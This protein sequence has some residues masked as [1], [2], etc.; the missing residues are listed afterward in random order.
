MN[1]RTERS[2]ILAATVVFASAIGLIALTPARPTRAL[3]IFSRRYST[4][5]QTCHTIPPKLNKTGIAFQ[6]NHFNWPGH[7]PPANYHE[8]IGAVPV[9]GLA[10]SLHAE[11]QNTHTLTAFQTLELFASDGFKV[12]PNKTGGYWL[13][14]FAATNNPGQSATDLD[15]AYVALPITGNHGQGDIVVG[16]FAPLMYQWDGPGNLT[17][18]LPAPF[19][20]GFDNIAFDSSQPGVR[21]EYFNNRGEISGNGDYVN[22]GVPFDGHLSLNKYSKVDAPHGVYLHAFRRNGYT[23]NG[24]LLYTHDGNT[25]GS[26]IATRHYGKY[27]YVLGSAA[28]GHDVNGEERY[29]SGQVDAIPYP[30]LAVSGRYESITGSTSDAYPVFA[31]TYYP[32]KQYWLRLTAETVQQ[33]SNRSNTVYAFLQF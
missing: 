26:L 29:L 21:Y 31:V 32:G 13:D 4:P 3:P 11:G 33:K 7:N 23:T 20:N 1:K 8:G 27:F 9:S 5:C 6:V 10:S 17:Q 25:Y 12:A 18:A 30:W 28:I 15:G 16:Q 24:A 19:D 2:T 22:V 14:Y